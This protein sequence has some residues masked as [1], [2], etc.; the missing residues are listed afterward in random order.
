[1]ST[2][3]I[4]GITGFVGSHLAEFCLQQPGVSVVGFRRYHL[5]SLRNVYGFSDRI[6]WVDCD[7]MDP[8]S[9]DKA[10]AAIRPE[11]VF[12]MAS[13]SF[14]GPSWDHPSLYMDAN[15]K[16]TVHL[17]EA[18]LAAG[19]NPR[20]HIPGSGEE[21]GD[22]AEA[23]LP[24]HERTPLKPVNPYAVTK[25]AQDLIGYV[26]FRSY[27]SNVIRTRA[28][29]HEGPRRDKWFGIPWYA[30]QIARVE[31]GLQA[32]HVKVGHLDDLRNFTHVHD[33]VRAYWLA[34]EQCPPGELFLIGSE[35]S[36]DIFTFRQALEQLIAMS[37]VPGITYAI[38]PQYVRPTSV[39]RLI[40]D[41]SKFRALTGWAPDIGFDRILGDTLAYWRA[42]VGANPAR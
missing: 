10:I 17:L 3:L 41:A 33:M 1:M 35:R 22:V 9:V 30:Y 16:M 19:I 26:Y 40:C 42:E 18:C 6:T 27:G 21:Y 2:V 28:F 29:N 4:T 11:I 39:P 12:H 34:V 20:I 8:K 5:S 31:Q 13:Q 38:D 24:I 15:Y 25:I 23:D 36:E 32:P 37:T 7:M 14:V